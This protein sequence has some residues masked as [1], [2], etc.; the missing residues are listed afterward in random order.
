[1]KK[2]LLLLFI[3]S[4]APL[5]VKETGNYCFTAQ[6]HYGRTPNNFCHVTMYDCQQS[7]AIMREEPHKWEVLQ[8]CY[9]RKTK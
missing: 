4:C 8:S 5:S 1:M 7:E 2:L 3:V 6:H 9:L